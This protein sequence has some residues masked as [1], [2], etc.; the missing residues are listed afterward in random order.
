ML[1]ILLVGLGYLRGLREL[2]ALGDASGLQL[3]VQHLPLL[4]ALIFIPLAYWCRSRWIFG[5]AAIALVFSLE[6]NLR[7]AEFLMSSS[8]AMGWLPAIAFALPPA[9]LWGYDDLLL[10]AITTRPFQSIAR[11]LAIL[12]LGVLFYSL[13]FHWFWQSSSSQFVQERSLLGKLPLLDVAILSAIAIFEWLYL[14]RR[15][16]SRR[17]HPRIDLTTSLIACA[18]AITALVPFWHLSISPIPAIA[19]LIF[20]GLLFLLASGLM[21]Q[22]LEQGERRTFWSGLVLLSLQILSRML[23]YE[24]GLLVKSL[25]FLLCGLGVIAAGL[26]FE[27]YLSD[28]T[29]SKEHSS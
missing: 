28:L 7:A 4:V 2:Y 16:T 8:P 21:R 14:A 29:P 13:S 25:V 3:M 22:G 11:G 18:I 27:R 6:V 12:V 1:A 15:R 9:L 10:P 17:G 23:E 26:W 20:N 5:L 19:I 24:E